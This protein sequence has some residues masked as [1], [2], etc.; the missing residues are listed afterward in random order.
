M[1]NLAHERLAIPDR[2]VLAH[3]LPFHIGGLSVEPV[4]RQVERNGSSETLEPRV[5]QVLV[6]LARSGGA[7]LTRDELIERCWG[8]AIVTED[9]INRVIS[10]L[11][12]IA[13]EIGAGAFG[14]ET[15]R[16]V[17]Y[18][19][20]GAA[21]RTEPLIRPR[22]DGQLL[23]PQTGLSRRSLVGGTVAAAAVAG[24]AGAWL[25][26]RTRHEPLP[27]AQQYYDQ[28]IATRGQASL[29]LAEQGLAHFRE[30]TRIDP[31][32]AAAW[33]ALAWS[34]RGLLEFG[35]RAD[36]ARLNALSRSAAARALELDPDNSEAQAALLLLRPFYG[37]WVEIENGL[38]RLSRQ[39]PANSIIEY[40]LAYVLAE[41]GRDRE[42]LPYIQAVAQRERFWPLTQYRYILTLFSVG[43]AEEAEN[44]IDEAMKRFPRRKDF[45]TARM[46]QLINSGRLPEAIVFAQSMADR[47]A[48]GI[49]PAID[50]EVMIVH[51]LADGSAAARRSAVD[52]LINTTRARLQYLPVAAVS[53]CLLGHHDVTFEMLDG[54]FLGQGRWAAGR[55]ERPWTNFLFVASTAP[56][57]RDARFARLLRESGL[58]AYWRSTRTVPDF[59]RPA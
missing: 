25:L 7:I 27:L 35:P 39:H 14:I 19:L 41:V 11:R 24:F 31:E 34:Y 33:G 15:V 57:R 50:F 48:V 17:G 56:L 30:A 32:F 54:Y 36:A 47:P 59:R 21:A 1:G 51:A 26:P 22:M 38:R 6:A 28:G 44:L 20:T 29:P 18:R 12:H 42:S 52:Q 49:E 8:G 45:W 40:N 16:G 10:R 55:P 58:E 13:L 2:I 4:T 46:R 9:A 23:Y 53:A 5:M 3:E 43:Q 37:N